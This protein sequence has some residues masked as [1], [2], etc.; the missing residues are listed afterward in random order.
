LNTFAGISP[1]IIDH[2]K[3]RFKTQFFCKAM[4]PDIKTSTRS[5]F[6]NSKC[7]F[8]STGTK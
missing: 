6:T 8:S 5:R 4:R 2:S 1:T 3:A 7:S